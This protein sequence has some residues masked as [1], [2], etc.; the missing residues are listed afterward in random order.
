MPSLI[1]FF[2][3]SDMIDDGTVRDMH[4]AMKRQ[5]ITKGLILSTATFS[6]MAEEY[7]QSRPIDLYGKS[8]LQALLQKIEM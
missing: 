4:E 7:A 5:S 6:R 2:R 8:K 3:T 1:R